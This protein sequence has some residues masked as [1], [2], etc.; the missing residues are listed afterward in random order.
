MNGFRKIAR[1]ASLGAAEVTPDGFLKL[2]HHGVRQASAAGGMSRTAQSYFLDGARKLDIRGLL[3]RTAD[4]YAISDN[5]RHYIFE[6]IRANTTNIPNENHDGFHESELFRFDR[7]LGMPVYQTYTGKPHHVNHKTDNPK[8]ARGVILDSHYHDETPPLDNCPRCRTRTA[9]RQNR[10]ATGVHCKRCGQVVC[11]KFV[12]ILLGVDAEKDPIFAKGVRTGQLSAGSMGCNCLNTSCNVCSHVAYSRPEFCEHIRGSNKGSFWQ[13]QSGV[14]TR[15]PRMEIQRQLKRR[16]MS[17][18]LTD[19]CYARDEDG[20]EVRKAYEYCQEV[21]FDEYS[22]V[23]QPADP[24]A[25]QREVLKT[26]SAIIPGDITDE[27]RLPSAAELQRETEM[28]IQAA[29]RKKTMPTTRRA[30]M[31]APAM[32]AVADASA[33]AMPAV[34]DVIIPQELE[35]KVNTV[36]ELKEP[37]PPGGGQ[38]AP[39]SIEQFQEQQMPGAMPPAGDGGAPLPMSPAET[40]LQADAPRAARRDPMR[41]KKAFEGWTCEVTAQGN[42]RVKNAKKEPVLIVRGSA[43]TVAARRQFGRKVMASILTD[44]LVRTA[45]TMEGLFTPR[46]AQVVDGAMDDMQGFADKYIHDSILEEAKDHDDMVG[47]VRGGEPPKSVIGDDDDDMRGTVRGPPPGSSIQDGQVDHAEGTPDKPS[48]V[49]SEDNTDMRDPKRKKLNLGSDSVLDDEIHDHTERVASLGSRIA[50]KQRP[51]YAWT[52]TALQLKDGK[53]HARVQLDNSRTARLVKVADLNKYWQRLDASAAGAPSLDAQ[54]KRAEAAW[55]VKAAKEKRAFENHLKKA[56]AVKLER[57]LKKHK[58]AMAQS[59]AKAVQNFCTAVRIVASRQDAGVEG[60]PIRSAAMAVLA[61]TR[62][63]GVDAA[64]GQPIMYDG[65]HPELA[66]YLVAD[67][68]SR[69]RSD[70][71]ENLLNRAAELSTRGAEYLK[72]AEQEARRFQASVPHITNANVAS[73]VDEAALHAAQLRQA[74]LGGNL[75]VMTA[76]PPDSAGNGGFDKR[77]AIRGA[78]SGTLVSSTLGRLQNEPPN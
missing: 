41:F 33:P 8:A 49:T 78:V 38:V 10:D 27:G 56:Y 58:E 17:D 19:F 50:H 77:S 35:D 52:V 26:A 3:Q 34:A 21:V 75:Q 12:E 28:L 53:P 14:W 55:A 16:G 1:A 61:Q 40:G 18:D 74:A 65:L 31:T 6:A 7:R 73:P 30:Q 54:L 13:K 48:A 66:G 62:Q 67:M 63:I 32:P 46:I 57:V 70:D 5:P 22:R 2:A 69:G 9:E 51:Q 4:R 11:D 64:S 71:I 68:V 20:F 15:K 37:M 25:L 36:L 44:G 39:E 59:D 72:D 42:V 60:A 29:Q 76:P 23:D 43:K 45:L 24:K 47:D